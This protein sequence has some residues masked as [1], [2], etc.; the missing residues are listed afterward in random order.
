MR[1]G[2]LT[3]FILCLWMNGYS[4]KYLLEEDVNQDTLI[5]KVGFSR[6]YDLS[7]YVGYG[8]VAGPSYH[9]VPSSINYKKSWEFREGFWARV[10]LNRFYALGFN[11]EFARIVYNLKTPIIGDTALYSK[12]LWSKQVN[13][14]IALGI[15]NRINIKRDRI[16]VDLGAYGAFDILPRIIT[17]VKP[18]HDDFKNKRTVYNRPKMMNRLNYGLDTRVCYGEVAFYGR[19]RLSGLYEN[20]SYDLPKITLGLLIDLSN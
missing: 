19:Y 3:L 9:D 1:Y 15:F 10:K 6:K 16:F 18:D 2:I 7:N 13:N 8:F 5:P 11:M 20:Q 4:Q 12:T 14:N 17:K